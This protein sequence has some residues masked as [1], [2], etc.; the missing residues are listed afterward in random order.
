MFSINTLSLLSF[1]SVY[2]TFHLV[3]QR[4]KG[5]GNKGEFGFFPRY[6]FSVDPLLFSVEGFSVFGFLKRRIKRNSL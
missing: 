3:T 6:F 2:R 5:Q 4:P 1:P